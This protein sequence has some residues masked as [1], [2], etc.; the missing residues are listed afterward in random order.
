M[1]HARNAS[2]IGEIMKDYLVKNGVT[3]SG[4]TSLAKTKSYVKSGLILIRP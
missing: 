2:G 3:F 4:L 1:D